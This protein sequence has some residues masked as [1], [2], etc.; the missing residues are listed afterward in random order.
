MLGGVP[1]LALD[2]ARAVTQYG[3]DVY[4]AEQGLPNN[5]V[6][7]TAQTPDG[8]L[9]FG[10][11]EGLVRYDGLRFTVLDTT[12]SPALT[13]SSIWPLLVDRKGILWIGT[14]GGGLN[15][16]EAGVLTSTTSRQ[17]LPSDRVWALAEDPDGDLWL[18]T[19]GGGL[20]R[21][22]NGRVVRTYTMADGLPGM[23][24]LAL[25]IDRN[26]VLWIGSAGGLGRLERGVFTRVS[27]ADGKGPSVLGIGQDRSGILY[28]G[29]LSGEG[30]F[31]VKEGVLVRSPLSDQLAGGRVRV[32]HEDRDG[33]LWIGTFDGGLYRRGTDGTLTNLGTKQGLSHSHVTSIHEDRDG[34]LWI[35]TDGGGVNRL[36]DTKV[37]TFGVSEGLS[38][39][40]AHSVMEDR[41]GNLWIGTAGEGLNRLTLETRA[42]GRR[43]VK[44]TVTVFSTPQGLSA[45]KVTSTVE[46][47]NGHVWVGTEGGGLNELTPEGDRFAVKAYGVDDGLADRFVQTLLAARDGGLWIGTRSGLNRLKDGV[48]TA[49]REKD[50]RGLT[51][52]GIVALEEE[53]DGTLWI[54]TYGGGL[55][56]LRDGAFTSWT[57][58]QGL[59]N[60]IVWSVHRDAEGSIWIGTS[61]GGLNLLRDGKLHGFTTKDGLYDDLAAAI[62]EDG[63]GRFFISC[64]KGIYSVKKADLLAFA[65]GSAKRIT[66]TVLGELD[67]M[68]SREAMLGGQSGLRASDGRL[69]FATVKGVVV[70]DPERLPGNALAPTVLLEEMR[71]DKRPAVGT[72]FGPG[73]E[74]LEFRFAAPSFLNPAKTAV[75]YRLEPFDREWVEAG[76]ERTASYTHIP[77]GDYVFRVDAANEDGVRNETGARL[78]FTLKPPF[79]LTSWFLALAAAALV[80]AAVGLDRLRLT[81]LER[82]ARELEGLVAVR[83]A[84]LRDEKTRTESAL[85]DAR[86]AHRDAERQR[87]EAEEANRAKSRFLSHMSHE[88][89]TPLNAILGFV[90]LIDR[91]RTLSA[92]SRE[93]LGIVLRN[94]EHLL[95]LINDVL[96]VSKIEAGQ[97][98]LRSEPFDLFELLSGLEETFRARAEAKDVVFAVERA[99]ALPRF[100]RGDGG[101]LRQ[102]LLNLVGN[103]IKFTAEGSVT[104][105]ASWSAGRGTFDVADTGPGLSEAERA[106][107]FAPFVQAQAGLRSTEGTGLGLTI[108]RGFARLMGGDVTV[109]SPARRGSTFTV[110]V[111]LPAADP[112][113]L[114]PRAIDRKVIGLAPGQPRYRVL[115]VDDVK[116]NRLL[117]TRLLG[118]VGFDVR[119]AE[120]GE[121]AVEAWSSFRPHL[122][123][124]DLR[125]PVLDGLEATRRIRQAESGGRRTWVIALSASAFENE[126]ESLRAEGF[127]DFLAK[128]FRESAVFAKMAALLDVRY[129]HEEPVAVPVEP[130]ALTREHLAPLPADLLRRLRHALEGA[131]A[132]AARRIVDEI[133]PHDGRVADALLRMLRGYQF[134]EIEALLGENQAQSREL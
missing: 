34:S 109:A 1:A 132:D 22:H 124:M 95:G 15:R 12:T 89:R 29:G 19:D 50:G 78:A 88:L 26:G 17:G 121:K 113:D 108:S 63:K 23:R 31:E 42:D 102:I 56:R 105:R 46:D 6:R 36:R 24:I 122:V 18:G 116:E 2:P 52:D 25:H 67:G 40:I 30:L 115:V 33:N 80:G 117:L 87:A 77:P 37:A 60:D 133:R 8:Y 49:F 130:L 118:A 74:R 82:R 126:L 3:H 65:A 90:Q 81:R 32:I 11:Q 72:V 53:P 114:A 70:V 75:R 45:G 5:T 62:L 98:A 48:F 76:R 16:Y 41:A 104:L 10:T 129:V 73:V 57:K 59:L 39:G 58:A 85:T 71:V 96:N 54:G 43:A 20:C 79:Y 35:G 106:R 134:D 66:S 69:W 9:W 107:L 83:T 61:G 93:Q 94:G 123:W 84:D 4:Q 55:C 44:G 86:A 131:D 51:N 64:L 99:E 100:V 101:K 7:K 128:P 28:V 14:N 125:M 47:A 92:G 91:D 27:T 97:M 21:L 110:D 112:G 38:A 119:E 68:R 127:D 13:H 120:D 103:A 111:E